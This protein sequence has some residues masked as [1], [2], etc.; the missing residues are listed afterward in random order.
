[1][2]NVAVFLL[3]VALIPP[4]SA[5]GM[6]SRMQ[7]GVPEDDIMLNSAA[8]FN[9]SLIESGWYADENE[10]EWT[11]NS[12][13]DVINE[14]L[15]NQV[16]DIKIRMFRYRI[17]TYNENRE[18]TAQEVNSL[19]NDIAGHIKMNEA[20]RLEYNAGNITAEHYAAALKQ[21]ER[22]VRYSI[23]LVKEIAKI[24]GIELKNESSGMRSENISKMKDEGIKE[25][26]KT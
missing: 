17:S 8:L 13:F 22:E 16:M 4:Y 25:Q 7:A 19:Q 18:L 26:V 20:L 15:D 5:S 23:K 10:T 2:N 12:I 3:A 1:M 21:S 6:D 11:G 9:D 14:A 24:A